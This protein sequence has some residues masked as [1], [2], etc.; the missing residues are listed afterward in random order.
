MVS[1]EVAVGMEITGA[2]V[3]NIG[4]MN[5]SDAGFG[6]VVNFKAESHSEPCWRGYREKNKIR[7]H[8]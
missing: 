5:F 3:N 2:F 1:N 7:Y 4:L 8:Y 6:Y